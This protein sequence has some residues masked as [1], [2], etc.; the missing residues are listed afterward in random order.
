MKNQNK[1]RSISRQISNQDDENEYDQDFEN[2]E[3]TENLTDR[4]LQNNVDSSFSKKLKMF[5]D[6]LDAI[7]FGNYEKIILGE[8]INLSLQ[9]Y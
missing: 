6:N 1:S 8:K 9:T 4:K 7:N 3:Q 2:D 5:Q